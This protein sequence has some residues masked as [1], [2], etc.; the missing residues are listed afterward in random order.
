MNSNTNVDGTNKPRVQFSSTND[1]HKYVQAASTNSLSSSYCSDA[2]FLAYE[3]S[4]ES[5]TSR[6]QSSQATSAANSGAGGDNLL[7][8]STD[9]PRAPSRSSKSKSRL[10]VAGPSSVLQQ[11]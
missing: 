6:G 2:S 11:I 1:I 8:L 10:G 7:F 5:V 4:Y 3:S 9:P